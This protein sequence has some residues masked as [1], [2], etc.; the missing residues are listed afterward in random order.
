M[1]FAVER[2]AF[3]AAITDVYLNKKSEDTPILR[4]ILIEAKDGGLRLLSHNMDYCCETACSATVDDAG[5]TTVPLVELSGL[6]AAAPEG[7]SITMETDGGRIKI[8]FGRGTYRLPTLPAESFPLALECKKT[9]TL[10]LTSDEAFKLFQGPAFAVTNDQSNRYQQGIY[11]HTSNGHVSTC[12]TSGIQLVRVSIEGLPPVKT[13]IIV[14]KSAALEIVK[15]AKGSSVRLEWSDKILRVTNGKRCFSTNLID[16]TFPENYERLIAARDGVPRL[17]FDRKEL[18]QAIHRLSLVTPSSES[19]TLRWDENCKT[20][21]ISIR[22]AG[23]EDVNCESDGVAAGTIKLPPSQFYTML[24][25]IDD[26]QVDL[27][28][29]A[30]N[31][32]LQIGIPTRPHYAALQSPTVGK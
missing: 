1:K 26:K 24:S 17:R 6:V 3:L 15:A 18:A 7:A 29:V 5:V 10:D 32:P 2:E 8:R 16:A 25:E 4:N 13:G 22:D 12:A 28:C 9:D 14:S 11:L 19:V 31:K 27:Y 20:V 30:A 21:A 23:S